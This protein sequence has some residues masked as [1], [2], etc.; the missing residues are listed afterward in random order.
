MA[1]K[2]VPDASV[3]LEWADNTLQFTEA[4]YKDTRIPADACFGSQQAAEKAL[5]AFL[6]AHDTEPPRIHDTAALLELAR[7]ID[8]G[9]TGLEEHCKLL[10]R[11]VVQARYPGDL[12]RDFRDEEA[13]RALTAARA[14]VEVIKKRL[15]RGAR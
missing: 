3:W 2:L 14:V 4:G 13:P 7:R 1:Q 6:I 9:I 15:G 11:Y 10:T 5:K 12:F 8:P